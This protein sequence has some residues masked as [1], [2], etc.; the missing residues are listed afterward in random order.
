MA[1]STVKLHRDV[2]NH[3]DEPTVQYEDRTPLRKGEVPILE[4]KE[5]SYGAVDGQT[6]DKTELIGRNTQ[7]M[8]VST[9]TMCPISIPKPLRKLRVIHMVIKRK[10]SRRPMERKK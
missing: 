5:H 1:Y 3:E 10:L 9:S 4:G 6:E 8:R 2:Q 7:G